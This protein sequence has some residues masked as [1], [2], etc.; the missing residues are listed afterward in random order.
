[1]LWLGIARLTAG[2]GLEVCFH[3]ASHQVELVIKLVLEADQTE[4]VP[5][6]VLTVIIRMGATRTAQCAAVLTWLL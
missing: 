5:R 1:M 6:Y 4:T 2:T 3:L